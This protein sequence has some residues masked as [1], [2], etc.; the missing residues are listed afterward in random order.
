MR[1]RRL[2][3][4]LIA[5]CNQVFVLLISRNHILLQ[6]VFN[7]RVTGVYNVD[8]SLISVSGVSAGGYM[9]V[10]FHVAFSS[11]IMGAGIV[12]AGMDA[13]WYCMIDIG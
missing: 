1:G 10:Q 7:S 6:E 13:V 8:T 9:A 2:F 5:L 11:S 4:L 12:A 3:I